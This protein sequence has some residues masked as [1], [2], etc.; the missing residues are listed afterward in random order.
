[1]DQC[2]FVVVGLTY[3]EASVVCR[4]FFVSYLG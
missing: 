4:G 1:M 2:D 3:E